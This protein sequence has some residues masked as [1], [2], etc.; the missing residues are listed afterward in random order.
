M[1]KYDC[2][3]QVVTATIVTADGEK[4]VG[5]NW[6]QNRVEIC[7]RVSAGCA[8]G[9]GY[10]LCKEVCEQVGHAEIVALSI[11]GDKAKGSTLFLEGHTYACDP[12][13]SACHE[14]GIKEIIIGAVP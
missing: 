12:C 10:H 9:E 14:A 7:P 6:I 5:K 13:K 8:S 4:F 2:K 11:A 3:K 1:N